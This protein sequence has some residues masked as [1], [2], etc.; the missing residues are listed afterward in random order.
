MRDLDSQ[1]GKISTTLLESIWGM[2]L[3]HPPSKFGLGIRVMNSVT[4][5]LHPLSLV[6]L[7]VHVRDRYEA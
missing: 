7:G 1:D 2:Q 5:A 6:T 4:D 3:P